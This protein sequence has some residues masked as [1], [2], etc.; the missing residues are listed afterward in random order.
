[1]SNNKFEVPADVPAEYREEYIKNYS[2]ATQ[3]C[4]RLMLFAGDQK[5]EHLNQDFYG[6]DIASEDG[7]PKH[8]FNIA[9]QGKI[10]VFA[11]Q[12]GLIAQYGKTAPDVSYMVKLN[13]K[14]NL[15]K[16]DLQDPRSPLLYPIS[17]VVEF[18]K[19]S[20]L[21]I[22]GVGFTLYLGSEFEGEMMVDAAR[23][24]YEAHLHGLLATLWVY[25]RGKSVSNEKD[26][27]VIAGAAGVAACLGADFVK[28]NAPKKE[29]VDSAVL[30]QQAVMAAGKTKV[31]CAGGSGTDVKSFLTSLYAQIHTGGT[32]GNAT[33]RNIHQKPLDE[34][35]RFCNAIYAVTVENKTVEEA[36]NIYQ[37]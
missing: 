5:I 23:V 10:G 17:K 37:P 35:V 28:V 2:L 18:K 11:S 1:M 20:G 14:T 24:V 16:K 30:L 27:D 33:G 7:D 12:L 22:V 19:N 15:M 36:M 8:L 9:S 32:A 13:S 34:A 4:G 3:N 25:P 31:V 29:G 21:H 26:P 6:E